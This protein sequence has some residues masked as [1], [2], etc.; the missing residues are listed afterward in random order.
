VHAKRY[1]TPT[2]VAAAA[3]VAVTRSRATDGRSEFK[4]QQGKLIAIF[5]FPAR[6]LSSQQDR[7]LNVTNRSVFSDVK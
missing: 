4:V 2:E 6:T 1:L 3:T 5:S 7:T